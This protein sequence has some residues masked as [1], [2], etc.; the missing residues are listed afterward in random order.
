MLHKG[1][2]AYRMAFGASDAE[3][4]K[5]LPAVERLVNFLRYLP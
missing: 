4:K 1:D 2:R 3:W 5:N